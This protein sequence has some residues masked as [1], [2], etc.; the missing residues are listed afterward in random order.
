MKHFKPT[1]P[2]Q[3]TKTVVDY[4]SLTKKE[5]EK[6]LIAPLSRKHGRSRGRITVRHKGGGHKRKYRIIDFKGDKFDIPAKVASLEYDPNRSAFIALLSYKDGEK[7]YILAPKDITVGK[8]L[9][10]SKKKLSLEAGNRMPLK[11]LPIGRSTPR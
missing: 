3:R 2:G 4:S 1:T 8:I 10:N 11:F 6:S 9:M 7:R 5:P